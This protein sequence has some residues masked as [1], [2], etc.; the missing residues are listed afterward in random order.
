[1]EE[2]RLLTLKEQMASLSNGI[3]PIS[4]V[5][6]TND[7]I[8]NNR[9]LQ[10]SFRDVA[11]AMES[12]IALRLDEKPREKRKPFTLSEEVK[13]NILS[14]ESITIS[15]FVE[16]INSGTDKSAMQQLKVGDITN[17]LTAENY[18]QD[19]NTNEEIFFRRAT[20][21]GLSI[22]INVLERTDSKGRK[23][24]VNMYNTDAQQFILN[25][26]DEML[27]YLRSK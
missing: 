6:V 7:S 26:L 9:E 12:L 3:D 8:L 11:V 15:K 25:N 24:V 21:K 18:L 1:M 20:G 2:K 5:A 13:E 27:K 22:G 10:L 16:G 23:Y 19:D 17:W 14:I 4:G